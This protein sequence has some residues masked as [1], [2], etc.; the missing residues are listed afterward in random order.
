MRESF[1][2]RLRYTP[3]FAC[4][5]PQKVQGMISYSVALICCLKLT[6]TAQLLPPQLK[7]VLRSSAQYQIQSESPVRL[8]PEWHHLQSP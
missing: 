4:K 3:V 6:L 2:N 8:A 1:R 5:V 7:L